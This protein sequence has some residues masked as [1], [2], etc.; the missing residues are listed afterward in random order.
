MVIPSLRLNC[1]ELL[2]FLC[3]NQGTICIYLILA[4]TALWGELLG[5][6]PAS[7][8]FWLLITQARTFD[9]PEQRECFESRPRALIIR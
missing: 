9:E 5:L 2:L 4:T 1:W 8:R 6:L 7:V 3:Y